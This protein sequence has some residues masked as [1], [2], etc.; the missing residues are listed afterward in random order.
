MPCVFDKI[1]SEVA[2]GEKTYYIQFEGRTIDLK[3]YLRENGIEIDNPNNNDN[4]GMID[5]N[6]TPTPNLDLETPNVVQKP[7]PSPSPS[8]EPS[9]VDEPTPIENIDNEN[10]L[11]TA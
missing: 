6:A 2:G 1:Y 5:L 11:P 3:T 8:P 7:T 4:P 9:P 10:H